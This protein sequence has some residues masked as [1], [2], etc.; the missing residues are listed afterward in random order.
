MNPTE[1]PVDIEALNPKEFAYDSKMDTGLLM[2]PECVERIFWCRNLSGSRIFISRGVAETGHVSNSTHYL[3]PC[4]A[5]DI[6]FMDKGFKEVSQIVRRAG[7]KGVGRYV[8]WHYN[9]KPTCGFHVDTFIGD[10]IRPRPLE[11][12][13]HDGDYIYTTPVAVS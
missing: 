12:F 2:D 5:A 7:F 6:I 1:W 13:Y 9:G 3:R 10:T 8:N 4:P 11:W